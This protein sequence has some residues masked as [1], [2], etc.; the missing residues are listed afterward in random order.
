MI[1]FTPV[2]QLG[3]S[4]SC[5]SIARQLVLEPTLFSDTV[6]RRASGACAGAAGDGAGEV[7]V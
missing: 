4:G 7:C 6:L 1:H 3:E 2:Q 5:Y